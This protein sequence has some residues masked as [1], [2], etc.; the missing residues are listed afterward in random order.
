MTEAA[1][2]EAS[3]VEDAPPSGRQVIAVLLGSGAIGFLLG[4]LAY[5][6]WQDALEP[7]QV[8]AGIV[9]YPLHNLVYLHS[10]RPLTAL[11]QILALPLYA[12]VTERALALILSG[13]TGMLSMQA[14]GMVVLALSGDVL[15]ATLAP[16]FILVTNSTVGGVTYRP[17]DEWSLHFAYDVATTNGA[18]HVVEDLAMRNEGIVATRIV[19][20]TACA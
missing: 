1:R 7:A 20:I 4:V 18:V 5:P 11:N 16:F 12:G 3:A 19:P 8:L 10:T 13:A 14:L 9:N 15:L 2:L 17:G 6:S